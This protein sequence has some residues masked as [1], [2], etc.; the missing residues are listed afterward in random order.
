MIELTEQQRRAL[1]DVADQTAIIETNSSCLLVR[2]ELVAR[3]KNALDLGDYDPDEG[4]A[5]IN[6][7]MAED[8]ANDP[9]L[10]QYQNI[11]KAP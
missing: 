2:K 6:E 5:Y 1:D 8:D 9:L 11:R 7:I 4:L 10:A 3:L